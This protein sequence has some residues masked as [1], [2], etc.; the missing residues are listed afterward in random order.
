MKFVPVPIMV[1]PTKG[2][3]VLF[4]IWDTRVQDYGAFVTE[5]KHEW[6]K[7]SFKQEPAHPAVNV[8]WDDAQAFCNWL[9]AHERKAGKLGAKER[10]RLPTDHEWS[11]AVGIGE[12]DDAAKPPKE[13]DRQPDDV[14]PWGATWGATW[15][16]SK[17]AGN[18]KSDVGVDTYENT[19]PVGSFPANR[20][21]LYDM[22][23]N[24]WQWC[25]D[26]YD[27]RDG[28]L[29]LRGAS[30]SSTG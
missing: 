5:T 20:Y 25:E 28:Y 24:V 9:T 17:D 1:G 14:F 27:V 30:W 15:P 13:K 26:M 2:K 16:P 10:Y 12:Q 21:G 8:S 4:S 18:Y 22:G 23:G 7:A 3:R 11:C 19:S 29:V 6:P